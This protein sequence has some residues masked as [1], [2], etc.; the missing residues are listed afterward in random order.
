[1]TARTRSFER[2]CAMRRTISVLVAAVL[3]G[4]LTAGCSQRLRAERDGRDLAD[5]V[6]D[7]RDAT[8]A[9]AA[10]SAIEGIDKEIDDLAKR[11]GS[12]TAEDRRDIENNLADLSE[13]AIQGND[14]LMQ[15]DLAVLKRS[16]EHVRGDAGD[17]QESAWDGFSEG[18]QECATD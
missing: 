9:D 14:V 16:V 15:Q 17:V 3:V 8:T 6:C 12:A 13:H 18:I 2:N 4:L 7:L 1:M 5:S 11:Y 10:K